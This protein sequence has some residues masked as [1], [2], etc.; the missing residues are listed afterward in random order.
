[1]GL[2]VA[3]VLALT[4]GSLARLPDWKSGIALHEAS[5]RTSGGAPRATLN[6]GG[7]LA[8][9]RRH[10][11]ALQIL[12]PLT[13]SGGKLNATQMASGLAALGMSHMA[14]CDFDAGWTAA[15]RAAPLDPLNAGAWAAMGLCHGRRGEHRQGLE[16]F[17]R[18]VELRPLDKGLRGNL[19]TARAR[20]AEQA[21]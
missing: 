10:Q 19:D 17:S 5:W 21:K 20:V 16:C 7:A 13:L 2:A 15:E 4:A 11:E 8:N 3:W 9:S 1:M 6:Y 18:A 12:T 14:L